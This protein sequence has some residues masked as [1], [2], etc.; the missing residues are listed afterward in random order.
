MIVSDWL[1]ITKL[2]RVEKKLRRA[3]KVKLPQITKQM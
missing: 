1:K 3:Q 2:F